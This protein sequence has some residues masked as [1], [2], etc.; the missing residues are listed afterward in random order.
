M[1][2]IIMPVLALLKEAWASKIG[3][4]IILGLAVVAAVWA[5]GAWQRSAGRAEVKAEWRASVERARAAI[6]EDD[7]EAA[8]LSKAS[9]DE[10]T[11]ILALEATKRAEVYRALVNQIQDGSCVVSDADAGSL[12][13]R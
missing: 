2:A 4:A 11:K 12:Q 9:D 3:R 5:Y 10:F 7:R 13:P 8:R 6:K 1:L